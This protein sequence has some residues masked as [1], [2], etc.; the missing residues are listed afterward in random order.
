MASPDD[1]E[2]SSA[3]QPEPTD[4]L[5]DFDLLP[6]AR[7]RRRNSRRDAAV[8]PYVSVI[9]DGKAVVVY[10]DDETIRAWNDEG[11][12]VV[13]VGFSRDDRSELALT[14]STNDCGVSIRRYRHQRVSVHVT[15]TRIGRARP[16]EPLGAST[17]RRDGDTF[18]F[19]IAEQVEIEPR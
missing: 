15:I 4:P 9:N 17:V 8:W 19:K 11:W 16:R 18:F 6:A 3:L 14:K 1:A 5:A 13:T 2:E 12:N 7:L 10:P